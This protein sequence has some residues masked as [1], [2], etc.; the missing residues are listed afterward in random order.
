MLLLVVVWIAFEAVWRADIDTASQQGPTKAGVH[1][2][3][4]VRTQFERIEQTALR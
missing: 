3:T 1:R 2:S 4:D